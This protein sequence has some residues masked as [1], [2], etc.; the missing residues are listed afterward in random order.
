MNKLIADARQELP[1]VLVI[2]VSYRSG[3]EL[4]P[5][6][7]ALSRQTQPVAEVHI[8]ENAGHDAYTA[9]LETVRN[10]RE[11]RHIAADEPLLDVLCHRAPS[12]L[13]Y[14][15]GINLVLR[16]VIN[17]PWTHV[18]IINP[19]A[20]PDTTALE[21]M[22]SRFLDP[23]IGIAGATVRLADSGRVQSYGGVWRKWIARGLN[24]DSRY[25][26]D[27]KVSPAQIEAMIDYVSGACMLVSRAFVDEVG[28]MDESYFL[29][30]EEV[31][32]CAKRGRF[33]IG[34]AVDAVV[35]HGHG[36][37]IGSNLD[38]RKRSRLA[39]YLD[40][41]NKLLFTRRHH[42]IIYP[43][44]VIIALGMLSQYV[45]K[46]AYRNYLHGLAG[47][48]AGVRGLTGIPAWFDQPA[49]TRKQA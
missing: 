44:V 37:T 49:S 29:Y 3:G 1:R 13:G 28:M 25:E 2:I 8:C 14:A 43:L 46:G 24:I 33:Q 36:T 30:C 27:G 19:D 45:V 22:Q 16:D 41:R 18:W 23:A 31:D 42:L 4:E 34:V 5:L 20:V 12:N 6:L 35:H 39:V 15:G 32:W 10:W 47:W 48:W 7:S 26:V 38:R 17:K 11:Q 21:A 40:E 9:L